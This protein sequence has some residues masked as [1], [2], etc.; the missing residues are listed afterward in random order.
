MLQVTKTAVERNHLLE[1][2]IAGD[3]KVL[4]TELKPLLTRRLDAALEPSQAAYGSAEAAGTTFARG[5]FP[6]YCPVL[7]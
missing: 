1:G 5:I 3:E 4:W 6:G 2:R 7:M